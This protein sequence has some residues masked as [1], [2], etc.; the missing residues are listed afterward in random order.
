MRLLIIIFLIVFGSCQQ[1]LINKKTIDSEC[2][3]SNIDLTF[4]VDSIIKEYNLDSECKDIR[5]LFSRE[6]DSAINRLKKSKYLDNQLWPYS[7]IDSAK[8]LL[9]KPFDDN[10]KK[11]DFKD[12]DI[13][14]VIRLCDDQI[15]GI[16]NFFNNPNYFS[17]GECGTQIPESEIL[18]YNKGKIV[19]RIELSCCEGQSSC[20]PYNFMCKFGA[21]NEKGIRQIKRINYWK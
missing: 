4:Y 12:R 19:A 20:E 7:K 18:F 17:Y 13:T 21:I 5:K 2:D 3:I 8:Y 9:Y 11:L 15:Y 6:I 14:K 10:F 16:V 1:S